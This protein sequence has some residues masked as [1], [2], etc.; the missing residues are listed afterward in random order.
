MSSGVA[1]DSFV[2]EDVRVEVE[3]VVQQLVDGDHVPPAASV[4]QGRDVQLL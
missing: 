1:R 2:E 4:V 3:F